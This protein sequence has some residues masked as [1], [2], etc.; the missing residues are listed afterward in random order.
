MKKIKKKIKKFKKELKIKP[1]AF[2]N[3]SISSNPFESFDTLIF[4]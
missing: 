1:D 3:E 4:I 2:Q